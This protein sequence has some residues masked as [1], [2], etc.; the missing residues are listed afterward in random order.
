M[1]PSGVLERLDSLGDI[2]EGIDPF[3][4]FLRA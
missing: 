4:T 1:I 2:S 3:L